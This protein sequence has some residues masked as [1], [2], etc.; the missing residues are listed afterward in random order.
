MIR[1]G[2]PT[3]RNYRRVCRDRMYRMYA[4]ESVFTRVRVYVYMCICAIRHCNICNEGFLSIKTVFENMSRGSIL[5]SF[6]MHLCDSIRPK[7][8]CWIV[9]INCV[10]LIC[11]MYSTHTFLSYNPG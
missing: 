2:E 9:L 8:S 4:E 3:S 7:S 10:P 11:A 1:Q 5:V 6:E